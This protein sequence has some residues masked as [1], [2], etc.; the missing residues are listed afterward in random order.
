MTT[1]NVKNLKKSDLGIDL[2]LS[3]S[4][5]SCTIAFLVFKSNQFAPKNAKK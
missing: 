2:Y 1:N 5:F 4:Q 3:T